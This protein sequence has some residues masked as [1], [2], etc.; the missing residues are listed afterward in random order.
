M[1]HSLPKDVDQKHDLHQGRAQGHQGKVPMDD[2]P[3]FV[4]VNRSGFVVIQI[5]KQPLT[6]HQTSRIRQRTI[7]K[8]GGVLIINQPQIGL[9][10]LLIGTDLFNYAG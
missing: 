2:V 7:G 3:Q 10:E 4:G 5:G 8:C 1:R 9:L 6:D